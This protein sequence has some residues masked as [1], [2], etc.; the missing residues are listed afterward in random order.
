MPYAA[1]FREVA[2]IIQALD[3]SWGRLGFWFSGFHV[4]AC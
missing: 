2:R 3:E 1:R 4:Q